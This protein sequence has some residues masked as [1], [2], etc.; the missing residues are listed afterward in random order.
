MWKEILKKDSRITSHQR[1]GKKEL[2]RRYGDSPDKQSGLE[3]LNGEQVASA[4]K[5]RRPLPYRGSRGESN[6]VMGD[7][8]TAERTAID[9]TVEFLQKDSNFRTYVMPIMSRAKDAGERDDT[10]RFKLENALRKDG[11]LKRSLEDKGVEYKFV[12]WSDVSAAFVP[13]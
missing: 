4:R 13:Y 7:F 6:R 10:I 3:E 1:K 12:N 11:S 8:D 2:D 9:E 5:E